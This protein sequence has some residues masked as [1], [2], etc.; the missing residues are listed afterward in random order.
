MYLEIPIPRS[1]SLG[2]DRRMM[3]WLDFYIVSILAEVHLKYINFHALV[4]FA[5]V[6]YRQA[7][8]EI[9]SHSYVFPL[10]AGFILNI[11]VCIL[12]EGFDIL[13]SV[14]QQAMKGALQ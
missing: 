2:S 7:S 8:L 9:L 5:C 12:T 4:S 6:Q 10:G 13:M 1:D 11:K 14:D 3:Y